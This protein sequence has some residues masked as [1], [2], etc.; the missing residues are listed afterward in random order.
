MM[1]IDMVTG[2]MIT[3]TVTLAMMMGAVVLF[4]LIMAVIVRIKMVNN[5]TVEATIRVT[6][7]QKI[8]LMLKAIPTIIMMMKEIVTNTR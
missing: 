5:F 3:A 4:P 2:T 1:M 6:V 7:T 8:K